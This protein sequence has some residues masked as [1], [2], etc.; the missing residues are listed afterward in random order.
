VGGK[1]GDALGADLGR[2]WHAGKHDLPAVADDYGTAWGHVPYSVSSTCRRGNGLG[3]N[4]GASLD[5]MFDRVNK[6]L[7]DTETALDEVGEALVWV[8]DE[9]AKTDASCQAAFNAKKQSLEDG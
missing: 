6:F 1:T 2:I 8:A 3:S 9:Y 4:P 7:K 5:S